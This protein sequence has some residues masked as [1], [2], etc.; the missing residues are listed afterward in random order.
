MSIRTTLRG[1]LEDEGYRVS[2][3]A[4]GAD[5]LR[6]VAEEPPDLTFLDVWMERMDGLETLAEMK[7]LRPDTVVV[8]ISGHGTIE[9]AVKATRLGAYDFVEKPLSLEKTLLTVARTLEHAR[10]ERENA[11]L[12]ESLARRAEIIGDSAPMRRLH[13]QIAT[14]APTTGRVLIHGENGSGKELVARAIHAQSARA[15]RPFVEVNCAA[16]PEDLIESELFGHEKGAFTGALARR[17]GKF[18]LADG[19]T[20]F[21][22]EV[23]DMSL[24]TQAKVLRALE[25]QAFERVGGK[26]TLKVDVRVLAASNRDLEAAIREGRFRDDLYYRLNVIP[27]EVVPLRARRDDIPQLVDHFIAHFCS[28]NGKRPKTVSGEALGYFLAYD[29]PGNVRELRNMVERLVIMAPGDVIGADDL[30]APLR[31]KDAAA[32][33]AGEP[34]ER[35]LKEARDNFERAY[36]LAELRAQDWN[37]TRTAERLG[38]E[39]SH[40]YR[41]IKAYGI[42]PPK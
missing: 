23:G 11:A 32:S 24:K 28:E 6:L 10:L 31:P 41:K 42:T 7:R 36:I 37:M 26:D 17:R 20:L 8:M 9:T 27:I 1:V 40:L 18:E 13:E 33:T 14:A 12:R 4:S 5:A 15:E 16:I 19:G 2:A 25:E 35:S 39:R 21:L 34:R 38:I 29:W 3:A 22:D 30:P